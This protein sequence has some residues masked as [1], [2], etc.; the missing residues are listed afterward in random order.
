VVGTSGT[1]T[2]S[3][4]MQVVLQPPAQEQVTVPTMTEWG[5]IIFAI[6]AGLGSVLYLSRLRRV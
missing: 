5:M 1:L 3:A 4:T 2:H 6:L